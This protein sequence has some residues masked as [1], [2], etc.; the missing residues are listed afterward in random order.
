MVLLNL[1]QDTN[2][3]NVF[4]SSVSTIC[5]E[6]KKPSPKAMEKIWAALVRL[7]LEVLTKDT[8]LTKIFEIS[9]S[10]DDTDEKINNLIIKRIEHNSLND[11]QY[12]F[13]Q[14]TELIKKTGIFTFDESNSGFDVLVKLDGYFRN[15]SNKIK[16][17]WIFFER[18]QTIISID[19]RNKFI[20]K[21]K[22]NNDNKQ[23]EKESSK[24]KSIDWKLKNELIKAKKTYAS[25]TKPK[26]AME[27]IENQQIQTIKTFQKING[28][29][30]D[31]LVYIGVFFGKREQSENVYLIMEPVRGGLEKLFEIMI[32]SPIN[33]NISKID[34]LVKKS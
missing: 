32:C 33:S 14:M 28:I 23:N 12:Q 24:P 2:K 31:I 11:Y 13:N 20:K 15:D 26:T 16:K 4:L 34:D 21:K 30:D 7:K 8:E 10:S 1:K 6:I 18:R 22:D 29:D 27:T 3:E 9:N 19:N 25:R 17:I 5:D